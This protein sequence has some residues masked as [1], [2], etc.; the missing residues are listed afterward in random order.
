VA[1]AINYVLDKRPSPALIESSADLIQ[2]SERKE[3]RH[4]SLG[5]TKELLGAHAPEM[6]KKISNLEKFKKIRYFRWVFG[7]NICTRTII[8][9][10]N[11]H[12]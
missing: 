8:S 7:S 4:K 6:F 12:Y 11:D 9:S 2:C 3:K 10:T 1:W 5:N